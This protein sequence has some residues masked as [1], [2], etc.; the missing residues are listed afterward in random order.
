[1]VEENNFIAK[2]FDKENQTNNLYLEPIEEKRIHRNQC[3]LY[4]SDGKFIKT[5]TDAL[6]KVTEY[7]IDPTTGLTNTITDPK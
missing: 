6:G 7:D 2:S 1:M 3:Y 4:T 5:T